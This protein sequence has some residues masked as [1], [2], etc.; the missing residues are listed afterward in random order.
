MSRLSTKCGSFGV[1][2]LYGPPR[3]VT[4]TEISIFLLNRKTE[5]NGGNRALNYK[6]NRKRQVRRQR[7]RWRFINRAGTDYCE[8]QTMK[9]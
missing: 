2:Q 3:P 6:V 8:I 9:R 1:S 4:G 5:E 7:K